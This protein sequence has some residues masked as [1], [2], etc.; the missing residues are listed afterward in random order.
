MEIN[1]T[2]SIASGNSAISITEDL[3]NKNRLIINLGNLPS[4]QEIRFTC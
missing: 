1:Y 3:S 4:K 2:D